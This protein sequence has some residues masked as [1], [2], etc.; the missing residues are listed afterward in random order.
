MQVFTLLYEST[1]GKFTFES[2]ETLKRRISQIAWIGMTWAF[3][4]GKPFTLS[5]LN[6]S[7]FGKISNLNLLKCKGVA[8]SNSI[9]S[10]VSKLSLTGV[11]TLKNCKVTKDH[12]SNLFEDCITLEEIQLLSRNVFGMTPIKF[13]S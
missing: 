8:F 10:V 13:L 12:L 4:L 1:C 5:Q 6:V 2:I 11:I 7:F 9:M 3:C